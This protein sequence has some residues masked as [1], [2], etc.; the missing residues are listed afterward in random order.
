MEGSS[1]RPAPARNAGNAGR[2]GPARAV[3]AI[4]RPSGVKPLISLQICWW[5]A[6]GVAP[7]SSAWLE[8]RAVTGWR[9]RAR[10]SQVAVKCLI[11]LKTTGEQSPVLLTVGRGGARRPTP[12][13]G[14]GNRNV[15]P[16]PGAPLRATKGLIFLGRSK[17][18]ERCE[19]A[20]A[21]T[22]AERW[23]RCGS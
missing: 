10:R 17:I 11:S 14:S 9:K 2:G 21:P 12:G 1:G 8:P 23:A 3:G 16:G 22:A 4:Q 5:R 20:P 6:L 19:R 18:S 15:V 13:G 7:G